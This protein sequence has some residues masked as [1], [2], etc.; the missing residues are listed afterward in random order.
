MSVKVAADC[1]LCHPRDE[2]CAIAIDESRYFL[3]IARKTGTE[4]E[5]EKQFEQGDCLKTPFILLAV[6]CQ[7]DD[8]LDQMLGFPRTGVKHPE[9]RLANQSDAKSAYCPM[10]PSLG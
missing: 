1:L 3:P 5:K 8:V 2:N 4:K 10:L 9:P 6:T 7:A